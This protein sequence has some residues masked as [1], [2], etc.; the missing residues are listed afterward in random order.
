MPIHTTL[1]RQLD[2]LHRLVPRHQGCRACAAGGPGHSCATH[3]GAVLLHA[4]A[5]VEA[6]EEGDGDCPGG[7][8]PAKFRQRHA[9]PAHSGRVSTHVHPRAAYQAPTGWRAGGARQRSGKLFLHVGHVVSPMCLRLP[10]QPPEGLTCACRST[11]CACAARPACA[12]GLPCS[13]ARRRRGSANCGPRQRSAGERVASG[14]WL[15]TGAAG[16]TVGDRKVAGQPGAAPRWRA[17]TV[18][19]RRAEEAVVSSG[20]CERDKGEPSS[21]AAP[22][23]DDRGSCGLWPAPQGDR[24]PS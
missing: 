14:T 2:F 17:R 9:G 5:R 10:P 21:P 11:L 7:D 20:A 22:E 24:E 4:L 1:H 6:G 16:G 3:E 23:Q 19:L 18:R 13:Q 12:G 8:P 15:P